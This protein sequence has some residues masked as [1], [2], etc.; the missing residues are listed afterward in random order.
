MCSLSA[1]QLVI[2]TGGLL[3][4]P[5]LLA[6]AIGKERVEMTPRT[7][8]L[9]C[10]LRESLG[11]FPTPWVIPRGFSIGFQSALQTTFERRG[12]GSFSLRQ[13]RWR[14]NFPHLPVADPAEALWDWRPGCSSSVGI[15]WDTRS[16]FFRQTKGTHQGGLQPMKDPFR[17]P[18]LWRH[19]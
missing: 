9:R 19:P 15:S 11:S 8:I 1:Q 6:G 18:T 12:I 2:W 3:V 14:A 16:S 17:S 10:P 13:F 5:N 4:A 7:T